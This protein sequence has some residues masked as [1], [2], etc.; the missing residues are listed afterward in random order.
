MLPCWTTFLHLD[1][2]LIRERSF[3]TWMTLWTNWRWFNFWFTISS[4]FCLKVILGIVVKQFAF[5]MCRCF[6][7]Q[8]I[9]YVSSLLWLEFVVSYYTCVTILLIDL[10]HWFIFQEICHVLTSDWYVSLRW[11]TYRAYKYV[12][13]LSYSFTFLIF[14]FLPSCPIAPS[15]HPCL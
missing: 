12:H 5:D 2:L 7:G 4:P 6:N 13:S 9:Y 10:L 3:W 14:S 8:L 15:S 11:P 1:D